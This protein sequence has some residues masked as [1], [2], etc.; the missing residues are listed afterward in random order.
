V[1]SGLDRSTDQL[2]YGH[3]QRRTSYNAVLPSF[4]LVAAS[5]TLITGV[6]FQKFD[7]YQTRNLAPRAKQTRNK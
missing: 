5:W 1:T 3:D 4:I 2:N 6:Q 7:E